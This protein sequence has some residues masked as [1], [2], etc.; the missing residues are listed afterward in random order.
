MSDKADVIICGAGSAGVGVVDLSILPVT[1]KSLGD[2]ITVQSMTFK[3]NGPLDDTLVTAV[4]LYR[5][6]DEDGQVS[7]GDTLLGGP[8]TYDANDGT[9]TIDLTWANVDSTPQEWLLTYTLSPATPLSTSFTTEI[10]NATMVTAVAFFGPPVSPTSPFPVVSDEFTT[11]ISSFALDVVS[12]G[13]GTGTVTSVPAGI[14]CGADCTELYVLNTEVTLSASPFA[15]SIF[16]GWSGS[17]C[18]GTGDCI[19]KME[20][21]NEVTATFTLV[22]HILTVAK[23]GAG[24]GAVIS[25]PAGIDCGGTCTADFDHAAVVSLT[26]LPDPGS[27]FD[28]WSGD[29]DCSDGS[30]TMTADRSCTASFRINAPPAANPGGPYNV[31]EGSTAQLDGSASTDSDGTVVSYEWDMDN[32]GSY[33][34]AGNPA[35]F[36][37][38]AKDGPSGP[39]TVGLRV[40]DNDGGTN[41][42][43]ATISVDNVAPTAVPGGPYVERPSV[44]VYLSG[45]VIDPAPADT[46]TY[47]WDLDN[48]GSYETAGQDTQISF[49]AEGTYIVGLEVT[50]DD[51]GVGTE[52]VEVVIDFCP[53]SDD[54][55]CIFEDSFE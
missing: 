55:S 37:A 27:G 11:T 16:A 19:I 30:L 39:F 20:G 33:E 35:T 50:D 1:V 48:N 7:E 6:Y 8:G 25:T 41:A 3:A 10:T 2:P 26:P 38:T 13:N 43:Q 51:D 46:H 31:N 9:V 23:D 29:S 28:D 32:N 22:K 52:T 40:T 15:D 54:E 49:P 17:G 34:T 24:T 21:A 12:D 4:N 36:D 18:T 14:D 45:S 44:V 53:G 47:A 42:A 5:D